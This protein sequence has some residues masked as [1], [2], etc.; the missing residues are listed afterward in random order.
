MEKTVSIVLPCYNQGCF[1]AEALDS[2][3]KQTYNNWEAI[4][5]NDGSK[6]NTEEVAMQY[7]AKDRRIHY[8][9]QKNSGVS[10]ARNNGIKNA[11]GEFILPLDPD[12][13]LEP[14]YIEK[15]IKFFEEHDDCILVY[16]KTFLFG[17]QKGVW[18]L[19]VY[20]NY[21]SLLLA[22]CI[23]CTAIFRREDCLKVGGYDESMHIGL[24]DWEFYLRL[25]NTDKKVYQVAEPL[26]RYRIKQQ[27]RTTE[28]LKNDRHL[29]VLNYIFKKHVDSYIKYYGNPIKIIQRNKI[30]NQYKNKWYV[31]F[32][33]K[34]WAFI[35]NKF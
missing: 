1:L 12:D 4:I 17:T 20:T 35:K 26:F 14:S 15:C 13:I 8:I 30:I 23:V 27:S 11:S 9:S 19:P 21:A 16:S 33:Y 3:I 22:N 10:T 28:C 25:L 34:I 29:Q 32:F 5:V 6:D 24:E 2:I 7:I 31:K 18:D